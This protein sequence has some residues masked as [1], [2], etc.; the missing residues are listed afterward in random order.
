MADI[1][2]TLL[3]VASVILVGIL[4]ILSYRLL[5]A[6]DNCG[7]KTPWWFGIL[8]YVFVYGFISRVGILL[9]TINIIPQYYT[10]IVVAGYAIFYVGL[11]AFIYG[12]TSI[13]LR[14]KKSHG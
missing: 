3:N 13:C 9:A 8:P 4:C 12:M 5:H 1:I 14:I 7:G 2:F 6:F 10:D 11:I